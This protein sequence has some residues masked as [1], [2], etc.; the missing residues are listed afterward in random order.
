VLWLVSE[1]LD[2]EVVD[3]EELVFSLEEEL[4]EVLL[5]EL[6]ELFIELVETSAGSTL[7]LSLMGSV[8]G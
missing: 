8:V 1:S 7:S 6:V 4:L 3:P 5:M 2:S